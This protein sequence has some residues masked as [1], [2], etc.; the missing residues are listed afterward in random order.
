MKKNKDINKISPEKFQLHLFGRKNSLKLRKPKFKPE[1]SNN[2]NTESNKK[3]TITSTQNEDKSFLNISNLNYNDVKNQKLNS[4]NELKKIKN[5][6]VLLE[7]KKKKYIQ[8]IIMAQCK[9]Q[10]I[11][12]MKKRNHD[13]Y[14]IKAYVSIVLN[15]FN[16]YEFI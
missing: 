15:Y 7:N 2:V 11:L 9:S 10:D 1:E 12:N 5:R 8:N 14:I 16:F 6:I 13:F 4:D 3:L